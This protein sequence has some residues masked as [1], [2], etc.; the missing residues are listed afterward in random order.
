MQPE[1]Q[2]LLSRIQAVHQALTAQSATWDA[3]FF[4]D[5]LTHFY[6]TDT[7]QTGVFVLKRNGDF[8][9][10]IRNS[11]ALGK[12]QST[13]TELYPMVSYKDLLGFTGNHCQEVFMDTKTVTVDL[14]ERLKKYIQMDTILPADGILSQVR[15][16]KS[17]YEL[18]IMEES[19]RQHRT[20]LC[21]VVPTL[22]EEGMSEATLTARMYERMIGLGYHGLTRFSMFQTEMITGQL[23][24]GDSSLSPTCF[25][26][27]GGNLGICHAVPTLGSRER[28]LQK[29]DLVFVDVGYGY[30]GYH[31]DKTQLYL[32]GDTPTTDMHRV[33]NACIDLQQKAAALLKPGAVPSEIYQTIMSAVD[34][35]VLPYFMGSTGNHVNFLGHGIGLQV[36]EYPVIAKGFDKPLV[37][38]MVIALE[39][40]NGMPNVGLLGAEDTYV[41]TPQG[42][43]CLTGGPSDI[44]VV[45]K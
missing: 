20:L 24:F 45:K 6:L 21:E 28:L 36:D 2:E 27:A 43:R 19:G 5:K 17:P 7:M 35:T 38:N 4:M 1:R 41:V 11:L 30:N 31:T 29:G 14:L 34:K 33:H 44:I 32:F 16:V 40:K 25:D 39:P 18:Q 12:Q 26:G 37:E 8:G 10:F 42:G 22:L 9:Y 23:G 15:A 13:L 3:A